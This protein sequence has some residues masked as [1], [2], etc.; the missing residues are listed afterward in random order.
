MPRVYTGGDEH[1]VE[2][3]MEQGIGLLSTGELHKI[4]MAVRTGILTK[5]E[6]RKILKGFGRIEYNSAIQKA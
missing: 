4:V 6:A 5:I 3:A 1:I 2:T